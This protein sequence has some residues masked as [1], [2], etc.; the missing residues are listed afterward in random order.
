MEVSWRV[1]L[2]LGMGGNGFYRG[3]IEVK[4]FSMEVSERVFFGG[5][6]EVNVFSMEI[7]VFSMEVRGF[8]YGGQ[9]VFIRGQVS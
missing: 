1:V 3:Q 4:V 8:F 7:S 9:S 5:Q 6:R 2:C